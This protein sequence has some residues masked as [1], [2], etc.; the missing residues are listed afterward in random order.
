MTLR[1]KKG[2][3][4]L[5]QC[6]STAHGT[7]ATSAARRMPIE[8]ARGAPPPKRE[9]AQWRASALHAQPT[10]SSEDKGW[11]MG[12]RPCAARRAAS[13]SGSALSQRMEQVL[14]ARRG[15]CT[16]QARVLRLLPR[17]SERSGAQTCYTRNPPRNV[18]SRAGMWKHGLAQ[19][20]GRIFAQ[21]MPLHS[22][23]S[24]CR[25]RGAAS[26]LRKRACCASSQERASAVARKRAT[27][28]THL[29]K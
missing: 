14:P 24:K 11:H 21:A 15:G 29:T 2:G 16:S 27:R 18:K 1:S 23:W 12:A 3:F 19:Q 22:A 8:S 25:E 17:E 20:E 6:A 10:S 28:A 5:K 7:N 13:R 26:A 4:S 9:R